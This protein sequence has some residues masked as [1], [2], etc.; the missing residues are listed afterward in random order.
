MD[1]SESFEPVEFKS[2][3]HDE[4]RNS[5]S[6]IENKVA[7]DVILGDGF[8]FFMGSGLFEHI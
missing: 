2:L 8:D 6:N 5:S 3:V 1:H 7:H 4:F